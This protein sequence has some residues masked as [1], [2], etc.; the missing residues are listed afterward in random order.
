VT[1]HACED[2]RNNVIWKMKNGFG[3]YRSVYPESILYG[4]LFNGY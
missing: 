1:V 4:G 3:V 2:K